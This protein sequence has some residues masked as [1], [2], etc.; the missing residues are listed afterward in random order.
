VNKSREKA[1]NTE[2]Q[3]LAEAFFNTHHRRP[4]VEELQKLYSA[5]MS[6]RAKTRLSD[7]QNNRRRGNVNAPHKDPEELK[8]RMSDLAKKRWSKDGVQKEETK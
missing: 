1:V 6:A 3:R 5:E 2:V 8:K 4:T 7:P